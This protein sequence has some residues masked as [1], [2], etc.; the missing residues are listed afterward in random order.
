MIEK[1]IMLAV[2]AMSIFSFLFS[3]F[4]FNDTHTTVEN[5]PVINQTQ[6]ATNQTHPFSFFDPA[7]WVKTVES[8]LN[9]ALRVFSD[10]ITNYLKRVFPRA[11]P[12]FGYLVTALIVLILLWLLSTKFENIMRAIILGLIVVV[13]VMLIV[14]AVG[15]I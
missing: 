7:T 9:Y 8:W 14:S 5:Q 1:I 3:N 12:T 15:L 13:T 11:S 10:Y 6:T 4:R 2:V